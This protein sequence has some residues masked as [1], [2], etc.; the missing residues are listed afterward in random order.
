MLYTTGAD[1]RGR[2]GTGVR[3]FE[4]SPGGTQS[5]CVYHFHHIR[6]VARLSPAYRMAEAGRPLR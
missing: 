6:S 3:D 5:H 4:V 1:D 2:T